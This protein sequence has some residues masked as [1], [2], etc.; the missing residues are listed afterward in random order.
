MPPLS[1]LFMGPLQGSER[2]A[3]AIW[4]LTVL[5][6]EG[7]PTS[8]MDFQFLPERLNDSKSSD[9]TNKDYPG[10]SNPLLLFGGGGER[11]IT[12]PIVWYCEDRPSDLFGRKMP[13][14]KLME[15][16]PWAVN[17]MAR[18]SFMR[19]LTYPRWDPVGLVWKC[20]PFCV[21]E[22]PGVDLDML[23]PA[24]SL[25]VF[26][27]EASIEIVSCFPDGVPRVIKQDLT[28]AERI[29][30]PDIE[31]SAMGGIYHDA[32]RIIMNQSDFWQTVDGSSS[33]GSME[34]LL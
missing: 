12:M 19:G 31:V 17:A 21:F 13:I 10:G 4:S 24:Q 22:C 32:D 33:E 27:K 3:P 16:G 34:T 26:L 11:T 28:M 23:T 1:M 29:Q 15:E 6:D 5:N 30:G 14:T 7:T 20:P 8:G 9:W 2:P 18:A 25:P